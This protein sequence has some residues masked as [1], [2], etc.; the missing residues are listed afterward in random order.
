MTKGSHGQPRRFVLRPIVVY[1]GAP[2]SGESPFL[3]HI[4]CCQS[5][6]VS[7]KDHRLPQWPSVRPTCKMSQLS[8]STGYTSDVMPAAIF[9]PPL[10]NYSLLANSRIAYA[11]STIKKMC[12][13]ALSSWVLPWLDKMSLRS[14]SVI[15]L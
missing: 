11:S 10:L 2:I 4:Y 12:A 14:H 8:S 6:L 3:H 13:A 9:R 5:L 7:E 1:V 15:R